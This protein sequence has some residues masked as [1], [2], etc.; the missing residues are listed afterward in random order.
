MHVQGFRCSAVL[1]E[2]ILKVTM[3][4]VWRYGG[5]CFHGFDVLEENVFM[6]AMALVRQY[7]GEKFCGHG[8]GFMAL[9]HPLQFLMASG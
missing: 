1:E 4:L 3:A 9:S 7:G 8:F 2:N 5:E 6:V